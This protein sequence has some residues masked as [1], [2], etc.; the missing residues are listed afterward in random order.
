KK[1]SKRKSTSSQ[2]TG[3]QSTNS[4]STSSKSNDE[5]KTDSKDNN[6]QKF[7]GVKLT[8]PERVLYQQQG[9]T[10]QDLAQYYED[11]QHW[12]LPYVAFR[13]LSL[14]RCPEGWEAQC[15]F[16][17]HPHSSALKPLPSI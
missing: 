17:K 13:P 15:F 8:N 14:V 16:Q 4:Q 1:T 6:K 2:S 5:G 10:K 9:A 11:I 12:I 7:A 3:S